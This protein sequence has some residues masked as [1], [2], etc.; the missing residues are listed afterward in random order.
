MLLR[1]KSNNL[2]LGVALSF[3]LGVGW[4]RVQ[5]SVAQHKNIYSGFWMKRNSRVA[6]EAWVE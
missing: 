2:A 5:Y 1:E 3:G 4:Y 6:P